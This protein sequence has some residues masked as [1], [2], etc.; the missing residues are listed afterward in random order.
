MSTQIYHFQY[1]KEKLLQ[2]IANLQLF[3]C[4][5]GTQ[6]RVQNSRGKQ[7]ISVQATEVSL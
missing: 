1:K 2:V 7:A 4:F 5:L 3:D 6:E